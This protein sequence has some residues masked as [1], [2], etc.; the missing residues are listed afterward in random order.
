MRLV[1]G[2]L[3]VA[4][5]AVAVPLP[6]KAINDGT[7]HQPNVGADWWGR[8]NANYPED[9]AEAAWVQTDCVAA[10]QAVVEDSSLF[11]NWRNES[12]LPGANTTVA[13]V[14]AKGNSVQRTVN[15][16]TA[17]FRAINPHGIDNQML[18]HKATVPDLTDP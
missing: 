9:E 5:I 16:C 12:S 11:P 15:N 1:V 13:I 10:W 18:V 2:V 4:T 14:Y 8:G 3:L 6:D 17:A 7:E